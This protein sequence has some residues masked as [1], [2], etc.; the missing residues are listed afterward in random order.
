M[1]LAVFFAVAAAGG[2]A[3]L[4]LAGPPRARD[5][6]AAPALGTCALVVLLA[7]LGAALLH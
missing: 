5:L 3:G 2:F 4:C 6:Y 7:A 1:L